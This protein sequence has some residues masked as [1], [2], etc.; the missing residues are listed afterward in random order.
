MVSTSSQSDE[1]TVRLINAA[2][3]SPVVLVCEHA[4]FSIPDYLKHLGLK[5]E[6]RQSHAAWDPGALAVATHLS[7]KLDAKLVAATISRLV[8]D[9]N[10]PP[11]AG[12]AMPT[13]SERISVPGNMGLDDASKLARISTYYEPFRRALASVMNATAEPIL[14]TVHSFT[15]NF[16]GKQRDVEIGILHDSDSRL[17]DAMLD[18]A[19]A[20]AL[21]VRRNAPYGPQH[22]VTHTLKEHAVSAGH[23]NVMIEIRNDLIADEGTQSRI[24]EQLATW[25]QEAMA[26][27]QRADPAQKAGPSPE[28]RPAQEGAIACAS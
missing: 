1:S 24:A 2:G 22:G 14:V 23:L 5:P 18:A 27:V 9:C 7:Q 20:S 11:Q 19:G 28:D 10:R 25:L 6:D 4:S 8:Y 16:D 26:K 15:P 17:A 21:D 13:R 12:D 3:S